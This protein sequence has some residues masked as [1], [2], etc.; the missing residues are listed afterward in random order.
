VA[1]NSGQIQ[2]VAALTKPVKVSSIV[3]TTETRLFIG[4]V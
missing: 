4:L 3:N 2:Q 1:C